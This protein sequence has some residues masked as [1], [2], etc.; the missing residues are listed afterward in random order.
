LLRERERIERRYQRLITRGEATAAKLLEERQKQLENIS[1]EIEKQKE[2]QAGREAQV[3]ELIAQNP[4]MAKYV[5]T[6]EVNGEQVIRID[7]EAINNI[8]DSE[9]GER[10]TEFYDKLQAWLE[11]L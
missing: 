8:T 7:W 4:E 9:E 3:A 2:L 11:E 6:E 1:K 10:V 5:Y